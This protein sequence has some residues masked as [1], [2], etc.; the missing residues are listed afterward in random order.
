MLRNL[1]VF[2]FFLSLAACSTDF[3][4]TTGGEERT[5]VYGLLSEQDPE[6]LIRVEKMF[7]DENI[8]PRELALDT[9]QVYHDN[10]EVT[11]TKV[12][13]RTFTLERVNVTE[14][15]LERDSGLMITDPN[16]LYRIPQN[17]IN[18]S[19]GDSVILQVERDGQIL[20]EAATSIVGPSSVTQPPVDLPVNILPNRS[21]T[22]NW[23]D[24]N[25]A[26]F[27]DVLL[28]FIITE[29]ESGND[30][31][32]SLD[33]IATTG[34]DESIYSLSG[35]RMYNFLEAELEARPGITRRIERID[36]EISSGGRALKTFLDI[37]SLNTGITSSQVQPDYSNVNFG[38]GLFSS[39]RK[40]LSPGYFISQSTLD[41]LRSN[42]N[43]EDL[44]F[45]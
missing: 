37:T 15:A 42:P 45:R 30:N 2:A 40:S 5:V 27:Y 35:E 25:N 4:L 28:R 44:N 6:H 16:Y 9:N 8:P 43:T 13:N 38:L 10:I 39:R 12:G 19:A 34:L 20:A 22:I 29:R 18:I 21:I 14:Q 41:S 23:N 17:R 32:I 1:W 7:V 3:D 31:T 11:L 24:A 36:I 33:W 26:S